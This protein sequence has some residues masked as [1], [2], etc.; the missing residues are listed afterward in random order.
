M[1]SPP[2]EKKHYFILDDTGT[3]WEAVVT[4][5][6]NGERVAAAS[7][8]DETTQ[9]DI[10]QDY[11]CELERTGASRDTLPF[12]TFIEE[13]YGYPVSIWKSGQPTATVVPWPRSDVWLHF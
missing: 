9:I 12:R 3:I 7:R 4:I 10:E 13:N 1:K 8:S 5:H 11:R 2:I 6:A